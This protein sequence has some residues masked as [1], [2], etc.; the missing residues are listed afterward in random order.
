MDALIPVRL[1]VAAT[2]F[3]TVVFPEPSGPW[4][5]IFAERR[6][7]RRANHLFC[8]AASRPSTRKVCR[9]RDDQTEC[10]GSIDSSVEAR[11]RSCLALGSR[12]SIRLR[13][14]SR[15]DSTRGA[16]CEKESDRLTPAR[17]TRLKESEYL[18]CRLRIGPRIS[19]D[20]SLRVS[21]STRPTITVELIRLDFKYVKEKGDASVT[22]LK[23]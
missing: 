12:P 5:A 15:A 20:T 7:R 9:K 8:T 1:S 4:N 2:A 21:P 16:G 3:A 6:P 23:M 14:T 11:I 22:R 18:A 19:R 17:R 10:C 13:S